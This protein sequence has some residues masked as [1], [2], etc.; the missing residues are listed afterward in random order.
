M[1]TL[2]LSSASATQSNEAPATGL[3]Q[4]RAR[5]R[6][7]GAL[8]VLFHQPQQPD[9]GLDD[10]TGAIHG[11]SI[12]ALELSQSCAGPSR[13]C[14]TRSDVQASVLLERSAGFPQQLSTP[15]NSPAA[16][17]QASSAGPAAVMPP[18]A[19]VA[20]CQHTAP[21]LPACVAPGKPRAAA[22]A[23][24]HDWCDRLRCPE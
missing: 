15:A 18:R 6:Y 13:S 5:D 11:C 20:L 10:S 23:A 16:L 2:C 21:Q 9:G 24:C 19:Y 7:H 12:C 17:A 8:Q 22:A 14:F 1:P 3:G 4:A